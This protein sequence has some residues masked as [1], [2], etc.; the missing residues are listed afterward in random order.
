MIGIA[1]SFLLIAAGT[2]FLGL[3]WQEEKYLIYL[4]GL[5]TQLAFVFILWII[6]K[7]RGWSWRDFGWRRIRMRGVWPRIIKLYFLSWGVNILY[8]V[9]LYALKYT[10]P[11][12]DV[13]VRLLTNNS[14]QMTVLN[15]LLVSVIAPLCEETLFRGV[16]FAC[17]RGHLN[18][19]LAIGISAAI[20]SGMHFQLYG[21]LPRLVLGVILAY[22]YER[23]QSLYP[24]VAFHS[25][26]NFAAMMISLIPVSS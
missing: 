13:Y 21:F 26:N 6:H 23:H 24:A 18:K 9:I 7:R 14:W 20:F 25:L 11:D 19:W 17:L 2:V 10:F 16:V 15:I 1:V 5:I 3:V 4:N 12:D 22:L 8:V